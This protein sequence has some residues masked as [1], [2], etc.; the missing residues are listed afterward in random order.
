MENIRH[1]QS[2]IFIMKPQAGK[3]LRNSFKDSL[4]PLLEWLSWLECVPVHRKAAGG[5]PDQGM[6]LEVRFSAWSGH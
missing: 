1:S 2:E 6:Y 3:L 4:L 5:I